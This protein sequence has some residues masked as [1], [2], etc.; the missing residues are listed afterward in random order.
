M[1]RPQPKEDQ[2]ANRSARAVE[3]LEV[4]R[5]EIHGSTD[6]NSKRRA[7][8]ASQLADV[9]ERNT[10]N[11]EC[12]VARECRSWKNQ[13]LRRFL[14]HLGSA[15]NGVAPIEDRFVFDKRRMRPPRMA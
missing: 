2:T 6:P 8:A 1:Q 13:L 12:L 14:R 15:E 4:T 10:A 9:S 3:R 11:V 5:N 7:I